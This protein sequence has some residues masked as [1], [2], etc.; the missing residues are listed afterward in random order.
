[1]ILNKQRWRIFCESINHSSSYRQAWV[2]FGVLERRV[3]FFLRFDWV[4]PD[5]VD[6]V[7]SSSEGSSD[8]S[9]TLCMGAASVESDGSSSESDASRWI[10]FDFRFLVLDRER[11]LLFDGG[12]VSESPFVWEIEALVGDWR[13]LLDRAVWRPIDYNEQDDQKC[14]G[15]K[16]LRTE[17]S[18]SSRPCDPNHRWRSFPRNLTGLVIVFVLLAPLDGETD[19]WLSAQSTHNHLP[20]CC[21]LAFFRHSLWNNFAHCSQRFNRCSPLF[22]Q[23]KQRLSPF[24]FP[25][26][27]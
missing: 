21:C 6:D 27:M 18:S 11:W 10:T 4:V 14:S 17:F 7:V 13:A 15:I 9:L 26:H 16:S 25:I 23:T 19:S 1:M 12:G 20:F 3:D 8:E 5:T 24:V 2:S 22:P